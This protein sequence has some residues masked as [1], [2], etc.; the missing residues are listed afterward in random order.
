MAHLTK[1]LAIILADTYTLYL[2]TQNY[3]WHIKGPQFN[4]LHHLFEDQYQQL[5]EAVDQLAE[6]LIMKGHQA[7]ATFKEFNQLKTLKEGDACFS[8]NQMLM[9]LVNDHT[10]LINGLQQTIFT[11]QELHD[12]GC[13]TLLGERIAEHEKMR[14]MLNASVPLEA[15]ER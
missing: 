1:E 4:S 10:L 6:R 5:A 7:P 8:A 2:K 14:W 11:A 9:D 12:E 13:I 15:E 3:H